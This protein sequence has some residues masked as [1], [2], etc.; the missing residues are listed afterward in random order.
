MKIIWK[1]IIKIITI[2]FFSY[3]FVLWLSYAKDS[4]YLEYAN[5][6][7]TDTIIFNWQANGNTYEVWVDTWELKYITW[8]DNKI[9]TCFPIV[10]TWYTNKL[11]EIYFQYDWKWAYICSDRKLRWFFKIWAWWRWKLEN[12]NNL[13]KCFIDNKIIDW[14]FYHSDWGLWTGKARLEW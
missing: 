3:F 10:W 7:W 4:D 13:W 9:H 2:L 14:Y 6:P 12:N 8:S 11:G 5:I 1:K